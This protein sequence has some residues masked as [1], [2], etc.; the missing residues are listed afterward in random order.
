LRG[1]LT[2]ESLNEC[3]LWTIYIVSSILPSFYLRIDVDIN[4]A[5]QI[6]IHYMDYD[7]DESTLTSM[8]QLIAFAA[9]VINT[10]LAIHNDI[11]VSLGKSVIENCF[12]NGKIHGGK[13]IFSTLFEIFIYLSEASFVSI[14]GNLLKNMRRTVFRLV[15]QDRI[16]YE[17]T[18]ESL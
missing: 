1:E 11:A 15:E 8:I 3:K 6:E 2:Q 17:S 14:P 18:G 9:L 13:W 5:N 4:E 16:I 10:Q 7:C 12:F